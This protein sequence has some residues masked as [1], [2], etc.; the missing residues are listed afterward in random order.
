[1]PKKLSGTKKGQVW[2]IEVPSLQNYLLLF[3]QSQDSRYG[4]RLEERRNRFQR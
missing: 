2:L 3:N 1:M 4:P